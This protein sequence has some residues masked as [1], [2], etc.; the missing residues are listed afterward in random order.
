MTGPIGSLVGLFDPYLLESTEYDF[1]TT[2][3]LTVHFEANLF[4]L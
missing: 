3:W 2:G 4:A 1:H